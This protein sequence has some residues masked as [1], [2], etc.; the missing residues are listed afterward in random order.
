MN[1]ASDSVENL[2]ARSAFPTTHWSVVLSARSLDAPAARTAL[3]TL[4]RQY[5][6]PIYAFIRRQGRNHHEAEDLTQ[7]FFARLIEGDGIGRA[8][9][10]RG[11]FRTF[12]LT[13]ATNVLTDE[14]RRAH[15]H[16]RE[17][18]K[19][20]VPLVTVGAEQRFAAEPVD[21]A[22]TPEQAFDR[23]W[24]LS[25]I[26]RALAQ[27]REEYGATGRGALHEVVGRHVWGEAAAETQAEAARELGMT[28]H[29]FTVAVSR[30]RQRLRDRLRAEVIATVARE[31]EAADELRHLMAAVRERSG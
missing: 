6:Y 8:E 26:E 24:A 15:A 25:L 2:R 17:G 1:P 5:W 20:H 10:Q 29:A 14:W 12:L 11:R 13:A 9:P 21:L 27:L 23:T 4:C 22:L 31:S 28:E 30:L 3:A 18:G 19:E 16:K 7:A